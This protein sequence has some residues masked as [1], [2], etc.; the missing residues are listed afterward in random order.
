MT[1]NPLINALVALLYIVIVVFAINIVADNEVNTG[2]AQFV[3][4]I[5]ILSLFTLSVAVMGYI[6]FYQPVM[7]YLEGNK[8]KGIRLFFKTV[9]IFAI[10]LIVLFSIF[11]LFF[12]S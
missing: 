8:E 5:M 7:L 10:I 4:P 9:L 2:I 3:T 12:L 1:K 11:S 6:F